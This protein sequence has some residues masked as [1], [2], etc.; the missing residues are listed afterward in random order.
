M[1][2]MP[3]NTQRHHKPVK[4][5]TEKFELFEGGS[6]PATL[7]LAAHQS[8]HAI[9]NRGR[10]NGDPRVTE[11]LVAFTDVFGLETIARMWRHAPAVSL[12]GAL[13]R[14]Y[15]LRD[16]IRRNTEKIARFYERGMNTDWTSRVVSGVADPPTEDEIV[17]TANQILTG[18]YTG[19]FD[20]A[21]E[22]FAAFCRVIAA[23]QQAT[24]QATEPGTYSA[25]T[26]HVRQDGARP[27]PSRSAPSAEVRA[28]AAA[29]ASSLRKRAH[30]LVGTAVELE[31]AAAKWRAGT[32]D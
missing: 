10:A 9:V 5:S 17:S 11:R 21:L 7:N 28:E 15:A 26:A 24:A 29:R 12:P 20:I 32:L 13:W 3:E 27:A 23:G 16:T 19:E 18:A 22:R 30:A 4:F 25:A 14:M 31:A 2:A 1:V 8:A 6:D